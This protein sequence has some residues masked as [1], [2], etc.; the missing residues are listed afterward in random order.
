VVLQNWS[1]EEHLTVSP[2]ST[3]IDCDN[4]QA[5]L[6]LPIL[7]FS[8]G[9][10]DARPYGGNIRLVIPQSSAAQNCKVTDNALKD[11]VH[12]HLS[13]SSYLQFDIYRRAGRMGK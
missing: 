1:A 10:E 8:V 7:A 11:M 9:Q 2:N 6:T 3:V 5:L 12:L 13:L 4:S